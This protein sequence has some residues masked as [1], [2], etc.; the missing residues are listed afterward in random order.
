MTARNL[1]S[2]AGPHREFRG[3]VDFDPAWAT[4]A[5]LKLVA[6]ALEQMPER[7]GKAGEIRKAIEAGGA[8]L[9]VTWDTWWKKVRPMVGKATEDFDS[10]R[11]KP[12]KLLSDVKSVP[13]VPLPSPKGGSSNSG[14]P[15]S[16]RQRQRLSSPKGGP[17]K[18]EAQWIAWFRGT[19]EGPPPT[20]GRTKE[21]YNALERCAPK[22][23]RKALECTNQAAEELLQR[24]TVPKRDAGRWAR[25]MSR[26]AARCYGGDERDIAGGLAESVGERL[27]RLVQEAGYPNE[28]GQWLRQAGAITEEQPSA[29]RRSF[30]GGVWKAFD[31]GVD[32]PRDWF[33]GAFSRTASEDRVAIARAM[34]VAG[35]A[36]NGSPY[37]HRQMDSLL[38]LLSGE[39]RGDLMRNLIAQSACGSAPK[40]RVLRYVEHIVQHGES[41]GRMASLSLMTLAS[42]LLSE[43]GGDMGREAASGIVDALQDD[44]WERR[45]GSGWDDLLWEGRRRIAEMQER[46]RE[47]YEDELEQQRK[48][49]EDELEKARL[50]EEQREQTVQRLRA[51][52]AAGRE[53][54]RM[55]ILLGVLT[56]ITETLQSLR[57]EP[58]SP[59]QMAPRVEASL[60]LALRA[61]GAEEFGAVDGITAY[62]PTRHQSEEYI[63]SGSPVRIV[64]PGVLMPG[65]LVGDRVLIKAGVVGHKEG[66]RCK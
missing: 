46:Q 42:I 34:A 38:S 12:I 54:A 47:A 6:W 56:V 9:N 15:D 29:W 53:E 52:I 14:S 7:G 1:Q 18:L 26:A 13:G 27:A 58:D 41:S 25:L 49:Y 8:S 19:S 23:V 21:A 33:R 5:P 57:R 30:L 59:G 39:Q 31:N 40:D 43:G 50:R 36:M 65:K 24:R 3:A 32:S 63:A 61:G 11:G 55:D 51:E 28:S 48:A 2:G 62:D 4:D 22:A 17:S 35:L 10:G 16:R 60:T 45:S 44:E 20:R 37:R 64:I 66:T